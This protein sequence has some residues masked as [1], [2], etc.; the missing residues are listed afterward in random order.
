M[1]MKTAADSNSL[2]TRFYSELLYIMG[3]EE[4]L[5]QNSNKRVIT[6]KK[7]R[8]RIPASIIENTISILDAEDRLDFLPEKT[9]YGET[10]ENQLFNVALTLSI[11]WINRILFL[12]LL[13]A[14]LIKYHKGDSSW[15]FM[16][17]DIIKGYDELNRLFFKVLAKKEEDRE[18]IISLRYNKVPYLNSSLFELSS[19]ERQTI[20]ISNL[21]DRE[22]P[23]LQTGALR[24][25][26]TSL[27]T[28]RYLLNF[29]DAYDF[30]SESPSIIHE[31][32][33][34]LIN[35][36]VLG[37]IIKAKNYLG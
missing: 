21:D 30:S 11:N 31:E 14:Q 16:K 33:K 1:K 3:L 26:Y 2:N 23:I 6:R 7:P 25:R 35:A 17:P 9:D 27:P 5:D 20:V 24:N 29:L 34:T 8:E 18:P 32:Q 15:A 12:K 37:R 19:L 36:S 10:E 28:L 4:T 22:M 13:E